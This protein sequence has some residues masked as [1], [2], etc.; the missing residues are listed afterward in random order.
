MGTGVEVDTVSIEG[1]DLL[2]QNENIGDLIT[3]IQQRLTELKILYLIQPEPEP[4]PEPE[5]IPE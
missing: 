1:G 3:F 2:S 5:P 4:E